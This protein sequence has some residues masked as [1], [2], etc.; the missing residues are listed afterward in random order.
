MRSATKQRRSRSGPWQRVVIAALACLVGVGVEVAAE[1]GGRAEGRASMREQSRIGPDQAAGIVRRATGGRVLRV[2]PSSGGS[3][4][5]K[6]LTPKGRVSVRRVD[7]RTGTV[8][9]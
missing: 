1:R 5:V 6:V 7:G 9:R 3:Y 8:D 4:D 2:R